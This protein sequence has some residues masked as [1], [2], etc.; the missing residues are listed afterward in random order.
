MLKNIEDILGEKVIS[1][2]SIAGGSIASSYL[3]ETANNKKY[4]VKTYSTNGTILQNEAN[5][6]SELQKSGAIKTPKVVAVTGEYLILEFIK[7]GKRSKDFSKTFGRQFANLH[8][9]TADKFGF[10]EDNFIGSTPQINITL[11]SSWKD[12]FWNNR[13]LYQ[14]K[15]AEQKGYSNSEMLGLFNKLEKVYHSI[16][17]GAEEPPTLLHGDLWGGNYIADCNGDPVLI[18]PA[19]YYGN[20]EADLAMTKL[21]GGFNSEFYSAYNEEYPLANGWEYRLNLY[22]LY[23]V[24]NHLNI[25]GVGYYSQV[26]SIIKTYTK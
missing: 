25:F 5:G 21:F 2:S 12:F 23:H 20:R 9:T 17:G 22:M 19:V 8:K 18:D 13:L 3:I 4:F 14:F 6:L 10:Y 1:N 16:I 15:L 26:I 7:S 11:Y 24:L